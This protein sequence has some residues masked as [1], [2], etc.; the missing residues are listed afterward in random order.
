MFQGMK[1]DDEGAVEPQRANKKEI[2]TPSG[3]FVESPWTER[4]RER[5]REREREKEREKV[6]RK[7]RRTVSPDAARLNYDQTLRHSILRRL[8]SRS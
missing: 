3:G 2:Q 8:R 1:G 6:R 5:E 7:R 4:Q